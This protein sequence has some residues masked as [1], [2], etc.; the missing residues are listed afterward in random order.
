MKSKRMLSLLLAVAVLLA[1]LAG[2]STSSSSSETASTTSEAASTSADEP[3]VAESTDSSVQTVKID[4]GKYEIPATDFSLYPLAEGEGELTFYY[5]GWDSDYLDEFTDLY[6]VQEAERVTGVHIEYTITSTS[7]ASES[8]NLMYASGLYCDM[9]AFMGDD[10]SGGH[11]KAIEDE[12]YIDIREDV[13][14]YAPNYNSIITS[15][16]DM[17]REALSDEGLLVG[18]FQV[19][20]SIQPPFNGLY[21]RGDWLDELGMDVPT[22][23]DEIHD[24]MVAFRDNYGCSFGFS[25]D[26][27]GVSSVLGYGL[28]FT[29]SGQAGWFVRDGQVECSYTTDGFR[30]YLEYITSWYKEGLIYSDFM[31]GT[32]QSLYLNGECGVFTGMAEDIYNLPPQSDDPDF[33]LTPCPY[34]TED[35]SGEVHLADSPPWIGNMGVAIS[36]ACQDVALACQWLDFFYSDYGYMINNYGEAGVSYIINDEG[37]VEYTE[38]LT[39]NPDGLTLMSARSIYCGSGAASRAWLYDWSA[40]QIGAPDSLQLT[41]EAWVS[42]GAW[43]WPEMATLTAEESTLTSSATADCATYWD[44]MILLFVT[45]EIEL[46]DATWEDYLSNLNDLGIQESIA[47][48]QA[49][50]ERYLAR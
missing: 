29:T 46:N 11:V 31:S 30:T 21:V 5:G 36:T 41:R 7:S 9:I 40:T 27:S 20:T 47:A 35:G 45:C 3:E 17:L 39:N 12:V 38:L 1:L 50:Y 23:Y 13:A 28:G 24:V 37:E 4:N 49:A 10:Y 26:A 32:D 15:S 34:P 44:E 48:Q 16:D 33:T 22:T 19:F 8:L 14:N 43:L 6:T 42:D 25:P 2:C 18:F